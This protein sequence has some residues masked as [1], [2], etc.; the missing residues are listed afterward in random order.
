MVG[1]VRTTHTVVRMWDL[2]GLKRRLT[3]PVVVAPMFIVSGPELLLASCRAGLVGSFAAGSARSPEELEQW[4]QRITADVGDAP[5]A[6]NVIVLGD[7]NPGY[8]AQLEFITEYRPP[9][10]IS[11]L[12]QPHEIV[13]R[14]HAYGGLV[15]HDVTTLRHAQKAIE[16]DVDGLIAVTAGAGG[17]TGA[18]SPF[19]FLPQLRQM[20]DGALLVGGSITDGSA[21]LAAQ[22]LGADFAYM[23]T[24]FAAT[25]ESNAHAEYKELLLSQTSADIVLTERISGV[26]A[27]FLRGSIERAGLDPD[28]LP[29]LKAPRTPDLPASFKPWRDAWSAGQGVGLIHDLPTVA[30]LTRALLDEYREAVAAVVTDSNPYL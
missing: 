6:M 20:W 4:L 1:S 9:I 16:A 7:H 21:I 5:W 12:G 19:A 30:E 10:V 18:L 3:L 26:P 11:S 24:R 15:F 14:V 8:A 13:S 23:G 28:N 27:S 17:H 29:P 2:D 25:Q 22:A